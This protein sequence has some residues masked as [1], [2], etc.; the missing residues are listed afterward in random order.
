MFNNLLK[1]PHCNMAAN[2]DIVSNALKSNNKGLLLVRRL[3]KEALDI[4]DESPAYKKAISA[5]C[6]A[7][8]MSLS[9]PPH[10]A[11]VITTTPGAFYITGDN[12]DLFSQGARRLQ[13][14]HLTKS[15]VEIMEQW[16]NPAKQI[17]KC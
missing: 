9:R 5:S 6:A 10:Q 12:I 16:R 3:L 11:P 14:A 8:L 2:F 13:L 17:S 1:D 4:I 15:C 7:D